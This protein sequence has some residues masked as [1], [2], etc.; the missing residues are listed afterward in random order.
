VDE[1]IGLRIC[2][3]NML[4][5]EVTFGRVVVNQND[6][7]P[8]LERGSKIDDWRTVPAPEPVTDMLAEH[9]RSTS[10][11]PP[12]G[13]RS[14]SPPVTAPIRCARTSPA[15]YA[16]QLTEAASMAAGSPG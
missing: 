6:S 3:L 10:P 11:T 9:I 5:R 1:A 4:R 8:F 14:C 13:T 2:D 16:T 12:I 15:S 7:K